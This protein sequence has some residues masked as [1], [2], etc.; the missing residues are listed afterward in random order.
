MTDSLVVSVWIGRGRQEYLSDRHGRRRYVPAMEYAHRFT[1]EQAED[2][3]GVLASCCS[4]PQ[5]A[6]LV[7]P[8]VGEQLPLG[9][10]CAV[11]GL[12]GPLNGPVCCWAP[13]VEYPFY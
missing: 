5:P 9:V 11:C 4:G 1:A 10:P 7:V 2:L 6:A 3:A 12:P 8:A 13:T